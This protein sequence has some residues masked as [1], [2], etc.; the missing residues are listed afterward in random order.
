MSIS[1]STYYL[2]WPDADKLIREEEQ[3]PTRSSLIIEYVQKNLKGRTC[4]GYC[5]SCASFSKNPAIWDVSGSIKLECLVCTR[6]CTESIIV[7]KGEEP[8][9]WWLARC[10]R[11]RRV[12]DDRT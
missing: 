2:E 4:Y 9:G 1:S 12:R 5:S 8:P 3:E 11:T 10:R 6:W 7:Y